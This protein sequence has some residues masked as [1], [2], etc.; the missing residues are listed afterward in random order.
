MPSALRVLFI[1]SAYPRFEGDVITPWLGATIAHLRGVGVDVEVLAPAYHGSPDHIVDGVPVH[2]FRYA[3]S[4]WEM[5]S[6]D[7]PIPWQLS[8]R[9]IRLGLVPGYVL[10]A[11]A[12]ATRLARSERFDVVHAFWPVPHAVPGLIARRLT[13]IPLVSTFFGAELHWLARKHGWAR[14]AVRAIVSQSDAVTAIST[15]TAN[16]LRVVAPAAQPFVV[17]FGAAT[18]LAAADAHVP[19]EGEQAF[20]F[21]GRL[22]ARKGVDVLL[23][24]LSQLDDARLVIVGDGAERQALEEQTRHLGIADRVK[25]TGYLP[26]TELEAYLQSC[27]ALVLPAVTNEVAGTEGL[28]VALIEALSYGRPVIASDVG[29]IPDV[30]IHERTGLL[31]PEG[32]AMALA[33]AMERLERDHAFAC[34]LGERGRAHVQDR[35]SWSAIVGALRSIYDTAITRRAT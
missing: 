22:V 34:E 13:G 27:L 32:D 26:R 20:L 15:H 14:W 3:T 9:P 12:A 28:G 4:A 33:R 18:S 16:Q 23:A 35:F 21:V 6:H 7:N 8:E 25:F 29:G 10:A 17:P 24:A 5:L 31:V 19:H 2:R 11:A 30:V 1:A